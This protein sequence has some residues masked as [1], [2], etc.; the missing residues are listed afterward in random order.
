M[1]EEFQKNLEFFETKR[2]ELVKKHKGKYVVISGQKAVSFHDDFVSGVK[3]ARETMKD[4]DFI[5]QWCV[6]AG[7]DVIQFYTLRVGV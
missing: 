3:K 6:P 2:D 4:G 5:V 7:E 1:E